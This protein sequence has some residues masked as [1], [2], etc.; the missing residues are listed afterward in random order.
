MDFKEEIGGE[1]VAEMAITVEGG[2]TPPCCQVIIYVLELQRSIRGGV[3][4]CFGEG[5]TV[6]DLFAPVLG[7]PWSL[8]TSLKK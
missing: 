5:R 4:R 7:M 6:G 2:G 1:I 8:S 3:G